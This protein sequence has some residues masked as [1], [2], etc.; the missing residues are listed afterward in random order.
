MD[1]NYREKLNDRREMKRLIPQVNQQQDAQ[2]HDLGVQRTQAQIEDI[3]I[4]NQI[5]NRRIDVT[6]AI[7]EERASMKDR[8]QTWKEEDREQYWTWKKIELEAKK[9]GDNVKA[10][11]AK[12]KQ[13]EIE[14]HNRVTEGQAAANETG[15]ETRAR[16]TRN[17]NKEQKEAERRMRAA[18][19][20]YRAAA[21]KDK[22]LALEEVRAARAAAKAAGI[23]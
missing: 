17:F 11:L 9:S 22:A 7:A 8:Q 3:G 15:R 10:Q 21:S 4:N 18:V 2:E 6:Q 19:E 12:E 13:Q 23:D 1:R 20:Q 5:A 16:D 14:R